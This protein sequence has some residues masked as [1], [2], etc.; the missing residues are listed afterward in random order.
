MFVVVLTRD[1]NTHNSFRVVVR[2]ESVKIG[3]LTRLLF[4]AYCFSLSEDRKAI[5]VL[6]F[7]FKRTEN[8]LDFF[9]HVKPRSIIWTVKTSQTPRSANEKHT[10]FQSNE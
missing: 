1:E 7:Q 5:A 9:P 8:Q 6:R 3:T 4:R 10:I 2:T